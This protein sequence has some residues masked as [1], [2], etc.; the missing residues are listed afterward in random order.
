MAVSQTRMP[1]RGLSPVFRAEERRLLTLRQEVGPGFSPRVL[2]LAENIPDAPRGVDKLGVAGVTLDL[3]AEV[4]DVDV[5]RP[6][7][8]EL[9]APHPTQ[10]RAPR[11]HPTGARGERH[12]ELEL[13]V[14]E[15]HLLAPHGHPAAGEVDA[16]PVV[17]ELVGTLAR[18][19]RNPAHYR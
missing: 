3:L 11:E 8:S 6:L 13:G 5:N 2:P 19:D 17:V 12:Q 4:A 10:K 7:V 9:V 1:T 16:Q 14:G 15:V 18:R